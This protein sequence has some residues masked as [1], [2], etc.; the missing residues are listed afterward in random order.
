MEVALPMIMKERNLSLFIVAKMD[1]KFLQIAILLTIAYAK[2]TPIL[3]FAPL[4]AN[5]KE[6]G[7]FN[8]C[9]G[10]SVCI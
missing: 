4:D 2:G 1:L 3:L 8:K 10:F 9:T 7:T 6:T 5:N